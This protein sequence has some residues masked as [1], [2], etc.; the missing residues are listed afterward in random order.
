MLCLL[1]SVHGSC[2]SILVLLMWDVSA[3]M[4]F[5]RAGKTHSGDIPARFMGLGLRITVSKERLQ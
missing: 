3:R 4:F 2:A 5:C 1:G